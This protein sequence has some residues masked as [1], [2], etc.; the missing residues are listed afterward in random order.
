MLVLVGPAKTM[1][2]VCAQRI[3]HRIPTITFED[4]DGNL[5]VTTL[6]SR[7]K[8]VKSID[9]KMHAPVE[10]DNGVQASLL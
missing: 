6:G 5:G 2:D 1:S 10:E 8:A 3:L 7:C 9:E 4:Q